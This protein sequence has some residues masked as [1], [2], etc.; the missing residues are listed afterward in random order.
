LRFEEEKTEADESYQDPRLS[1]DGTTHIQD[2]AVG[3]HPSI[4]THSNPSNN[5]HLVP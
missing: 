4:S 3:Y 5:S 2:S 1:L